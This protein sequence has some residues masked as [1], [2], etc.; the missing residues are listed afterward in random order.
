MTG[1]SCVSRRWVRVGARTG[2]GR[3]RQPLCRHAAG[4][5][6]PTVRR[7][8]LPGDPASGDRAASG[9]PAAGPG[10]HRHDPDRAEQSAVLARLLCRLEWTDRVSALVQTALLASF[11]NSKAIT[12]I[13]RESIGLRADFILK[14][15]NPP[16]R[17]RRR[18][19]AL[20]Q[21]YGSR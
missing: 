19:K 14:T 10:R 7:R 8:R 3:L 18:R 9:R 15:E 5:P 11:E 16:F 4:S 2:A 1:W 13:D 6:L 17:G 20:R 21:R 12:A